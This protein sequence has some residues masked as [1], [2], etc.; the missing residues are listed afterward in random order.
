MMKMEY[1]LMKVTNTIFV[2]YSVVIDTFKDVLGFAKFLFQ[3]FSSGAVGIDG[4]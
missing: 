4:K 2:F 3:C 1:F